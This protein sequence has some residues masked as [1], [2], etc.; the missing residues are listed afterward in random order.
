MYIRDLFRQFDEDWKRL[1]DAGMATTRAMRAPAAPLKPAMDVVARG[2]ELVMHVELPG[3]EPSTLEVEVVDE[4][5]TIR[6][7]RIEPTLQDGEWYVQRE[8]RVGEVVRALHLPYRVESGRVEARYVNGILE[9]TLP[10]SEADRPRRIPVRTAMTHE[11]AAPTARETN[12]AP[13]TA[14]VQS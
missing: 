7:Q 5:L 14:A 8:R 3:V 4:T 10:R 11:L 13:E 12:D 2:D 9:V 1:F 6:A